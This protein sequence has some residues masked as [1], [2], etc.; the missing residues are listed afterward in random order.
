MTL[1]PALAVLLVVV[2]ASGCQSKAPT[3]SVKG[4]EEFGL[5]EAPIDHPTLLSSIRIAR[6]VL[7]SSAFSKRC[8]GMERCRRCFKRAGVC[9]VGGWTGGE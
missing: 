3:V 1:R 4:I 2:V 6:L 8:C 9:R 7:G 5:I